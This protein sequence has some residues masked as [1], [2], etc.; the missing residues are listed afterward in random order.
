MPRP[1]TT[2]D[3][4]LLQSAMRAFWQNGYAKTG[5][6]QLENAL[7]MKAPSI[8]NRFGSKEGLFQ[9]ALAHYL[10]TVVGW[11]IKH[12]LKNPNPMKGLREFFDTTYNYVSETKP[13]LACLLVS[14]SLEL[15]P[16]DELVA[17]LLVK[18]GQMIRAAFQENLRRAQQQAL[19]AAEADVEALSDFLHLSLQGLL[20]TSKVE[21]NKVVL[22]QKV[23]VLFSMLPLT[24]AGRA[25]SRSGMNPYESASHSR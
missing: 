1:R 10:E 24:Q 5:M 11:R 18:G 19:L 16:Q 4:A 25:P 20:V 12:H 8:Y 2:E 9:A 13:P 3:T 7:G 6:R 21:P 23:D 17:Q 22:E 15:N 14:S